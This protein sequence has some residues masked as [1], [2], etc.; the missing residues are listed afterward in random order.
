[1]DYYD[2]AKSCE[3]F[4]AKL[5]SV[6]DTTVDFCAASAI[7]TNMGFDQMVLYSGRYSLG[8]SSWVWCSG[9]RCDSV[10]DYV[11]WDNSSE[12]EGNCMGGYLQDYDAVGGLGGISGISG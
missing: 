7:D 4:G 9:D 2:A 11:N 8:F 5:V 3:S 6:T 10:F 1:M 12:S